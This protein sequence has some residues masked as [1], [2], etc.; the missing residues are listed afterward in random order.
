LCYPARHSVWPGSELALPLFNAVLLDVTIWLLC[1]LALLAFAKLSIAHPAT[2]YLT[3]HAAFISARAI[4][5]LNGARMLFWW[6]GAIPV[7]HDEVSRAVLLADLALVVMTCAWITASH[8]APKSEYQDARRAPLALS[9]GVIQSVAAVAIPIGCIAIALWG[10]LPGVAPREIAGPWAASSW[11]VIAQTWAGLGLLALIYWYGLR[12]SLVIPMALYLSLVIYQG[13]YRF[14]LL[15]SVILLAQI[16]LDRRGHR[17]P[18]LSGAAIL[19]A[20]GLMFFPLKEIGRQLQASESL[21]SIWSS[22]K[23][24]IAGALRGDHPDEMILDEFASALT[25]ADRHG[26]LYWG[27]TYVGLVTVVIPR[28]LW[29]GKPGLADFQKEISTLERPM[30]ANGMVMTMLG[31]FYLNFSYVGVALMSFAVAYFSG[32]WFH[33]AYRSDYYTLR[34]FL[35]LLVACNLI[36]IFR[37]GLISLFVFTLINMMPLSVIAVVH[38]FYRPSEPFREPILT[39]PLVRGGQE[40]RSIA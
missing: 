21:D 7:T 8:R 34:R 14:R 30:A 36:Q 26:K 23:Q 5:I 1:L 25:L 29:P 12:A 37:D 20:C 15:I 4:A 40:R 17:W 18:R 32:M 11:I 9:L 31:E 39:V 38:L 24:G 27:S 19:L 16:N 13:H 2:T 35:Y 6:R 3:F 28:Q 10:R 22:A 33:S